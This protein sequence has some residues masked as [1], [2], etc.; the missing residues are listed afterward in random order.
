MNLLLCIKGG[1]HNIAGLAT[2]DGAL[3]PRPV[4][5]ARRMGGPTAESGPCPGWLPAERR[6]SRN[7]AARACHGPRVRLAHR[8]RRTHPGR[9]FG[10]LTRRWGWTSDNV[11]GMD[12]VT[13]DGQLVRASSDENADLF[14][15]LRGRRR[16]LRRRHR[17]RL[18][19]LPCRSEV[20]GGIVAWPASEAP[21]VL[22][23]YR[24]LPRRLP[25]NSR[26]LPSCDQRPQ[27][28]GFRR[29]SMASR[30]WHCLPATVANPRRARSR[31]THQIVRHPD[32]RCAHP[33]AV[34][35]DASRCSTRR[36]RR[37]DV[38]TGRASTSR[39]SSRLCARRSSSMRQKFR[40]P[41][42]AVIL[43]QIEG[44]LNRLNG[45]H[46]P[47]ATATRTTCSTSR[48]HGSR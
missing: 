18:P 39:E 11:A 23:L 26:L 43:F 28:N 45:E 19:A 32:R 4:T 31:R 8:H 21:R 41:H 36:S 47:S 22:E 7:A 13:A 37:V 42:S 33:P 2:A 9:R 40:S 20:V 38:T 29:R 25:P 46:S 15:G 16:E 17:H 5:H 27:R 14:W 30:L 3:M 12:V 24:R 10:Y 35:A 48:A 6:G 44:A 34:R 1:G